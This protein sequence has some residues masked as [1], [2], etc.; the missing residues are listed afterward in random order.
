MRDIFPIV[1]TPT[2]GTDWTSQNGTLNVKITN[3][4]SIAAI[5]GLLS[6]G[7]QELDGPS[8][9]ISER[10]G[11]TSRAV[12]V[13]KSDPFDLSADW[14]IAM[15]VVRPEYTGSHT[16]FRLLVQTWIGGKVV[17]ASVSGVLAEMTIPGAG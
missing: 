5:G 12:N 14:Q 15:E 10:T 9:P 4:G 3:L 13:V 17:G 6:V 2:L 7:W 1:P 8:V 11:L 16:Y